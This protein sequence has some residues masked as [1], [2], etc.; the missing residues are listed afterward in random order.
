MNNTVFLMG[1]LIGCGDKDEDLPPSLVN[2][3]ENEAGCGQTAPVIQSVTCTN[4]GIQTHPDYGDLPVFSLSA[5]VTD[6]DG[7]L[8]YYQLLVDFDDNLD[9][10]EDEDDEQLNPVEGAINGDECETPAEGGSVDLNLTIYLYGAQ[11]EKDT[12]YEWFVRVVDSIGETSEPFMVTCTTPDETGEGA[13]A[14]E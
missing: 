4:S 8:T 14:Q 13:P 6:E 11:P 10:V 5:N 3:T 1:L 12:R 7:D 2:T 9:G